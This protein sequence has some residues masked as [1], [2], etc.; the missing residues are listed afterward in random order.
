MRTDFMLLA[1]Y[2]KPLIPLE[3][4]CRDIMNIK[5]QTARNRI[6]QGTFPVPLTR[7]SKPPMI[8]IEDAARYIDSCRW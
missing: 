2:E 8:H 4:F 1:V 5:P 3:V 6:A 7:T